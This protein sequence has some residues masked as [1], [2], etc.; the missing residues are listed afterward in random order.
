MML[1]N[2]YLSQQVGDVLQHFVLE[3]THVL[4]FLDQIISK[5]DY[6]SMKFRISTVM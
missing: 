3:K 1:E 2:S 5:R 4:A 6:E